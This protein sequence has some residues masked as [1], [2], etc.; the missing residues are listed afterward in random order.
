[1]DLSI[2]V[3][4]YNEEKRMKPFL[5]E[6]IEFSKEN[7]KNYELIV[8]NDGSTDK[9]LEILHDFLEI[10]IITYKHNKGKGGA[11][12][13][14]VLMANG[15]K[16]IF[17]DADGS[18]NPDQIP[19]MAEKL[20]EYDVVVGD[21]TAKGSDIKTP[22][23]R[24]FT[25]IFFNILAGIIFQSKIKDNLCGFKGFKKKAAKDLFRGLISYGWIFDVELFYKIKKK[26][27]SLYQ[28][29]L[30]WEHRKGSK[31]KLLEP[32]RMFF[33]LIKLRIKLVKYR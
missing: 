30:Y 1:M 15:E 33:Q 18:I 12:R 29:P 25:G 32:V 23:K 17:I 9:T 21:R 6:L 4:A 7:L 2:I 28:L 19:S 24:K 20:K 27:Y 31:I 5:S 14:G 8:V 13:E 16:I 10:K 26:N 3:P 11:V 22:K